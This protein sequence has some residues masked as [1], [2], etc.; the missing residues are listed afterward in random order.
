VPLL[1]RE[2][3]RQLVR[4]FPRGESGNKTI[5]THPLSLVMIGFLVTAGP[6]YLADKYI[7][8]NLESL[9][10]MAVA[11]PGRRRGDV[12]GGCGVQPAE[13]DAMEQMGIVDAVWIGAVQ[14]LS[15][16][17]PGPAGRWRR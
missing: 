7:G 2:R 10:V 4:T 15:R 8:K 1:F 11:L 16:C 14:I 3:I 9:L 12:G 6:C 13:S 17:S 5:W